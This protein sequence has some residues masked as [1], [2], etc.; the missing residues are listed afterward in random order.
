MQCY[1]ELLPPTG[2]S[3]ALAIPFLSASADNLIVVRSSLLQVFS[4]RKSSPRRLTESTETHSTHPSDTKL[5]LEKEYSLPG[6]V[7]GLSRVKLLNTK[8]GGEAILLAVRNARL[9]L[10]EWDPERHNISTISI[11]YYERDDLTRSPWLPDLSRCPSILSVDP[12]SRCAVF[13]FGVRNLAILPFHQAGDDL[14]MDDYDPELDEER[15]GLGTGNGA[16]QENSKH[17]STY[18]TPYAASFVLPLTALDPSLLHPVSLAF[19][20]EYR[21]PTFGIL[22]S[23]VTTSTALVNERKDVMFYTVFTLDLEQRAS[24]TLL[25]VSRLPTD[26]F[27]IVALPPPV[28][29]A[30]LIG[31]NEI[32]HVDQA[33]K[34]NAVGVNDFSRQVSSFS[35]S[36]QSNL[37][38]RLEGCMVERLGGES[39]DVLLAL[40]SGDMA[41]IKF[42]LDGRSVSGITVHSLPAQAGGNLLNSSASCSTCF[43]D[44]NI[45]LGSEDADSVLLGWSN[46]SISSKKSRQISKQGNDEVEVFSEEDQME[47]DV[48]EDDLYSSAPDTTQA[49]SSISLG[50]STPGFYNFRLNDRLTNIGPLRDITLGKSSSDPTGEGVSSELEL[51]ASQGSDRAGGLVVIKREVDPL[52]KIF[53]QIDDVDAVWSATITEG[54]KGLLNVNDSSRHFVIFSRPTDVDKEVSEIMI[55]NGQELE[56][57]KAPEFNPNEDSTVEI[58]SLANSTRLVQVLQNEVRSYDKDLGLAQIYPVWD[59]ETDE[60]CVAV[61]ARFADPY[62]AILRDDASILLLHADGS[63]DL[64]EISLP[65][66]LSTLKWRS[67]CLYR[68]KD[69][70]FKVLGLRTSNSNESVL[71]FSLSS[72]YKLSIF[73]VPDMKLLSVLDGVDCLQPLLSTDPPRRANTRESLKEILVADLGDRSFTSPYLILRTDND[74]LIVY[75]PVITSSDQDPETSNLRFFRES[76]HTLSRLSSGSSFT[77][78]YNQQ[79]AQPLRVLSDMSGLSTVFMPGESAR[80]IVRTAASSPHSVRLRG[81]YI[82]WL[83]SFN[84]STTGC[85]NGF[86]YIDAEHNIRGCQIHPDTQLDYSWTLRKVLLEEQVDFLTYSTASDTYVL[87]TSVNVDFKLPENDELHPEWR[88]ESTS[89]LPKVPQTSVN[90][91]SP[92]TWTIIDSYPLELAEHIT[93]VKNVNLEISEN[94]HER[95][96]LIVVGT[97]MAKGEDIP[98][99]GCIY[100]FEVIEVVPDPEKPETGRKLKLI[101]KESVK[102]AVTALSGIGGQGF[103]IV[104]QGQ[105]CMVRGLKEDGSLLPVAFMDMQCY[106]NV[107]KELKGTGLVLLGDAVKGLWFA[108]YSEDPYKMTL[109]GKDPEYLEVVAA[110]FL[111]DSNKLYM[112]VADSDC[113]LHVMQYDPEDPKSSNGDR[114]LNRSK[115]YTGNF[116]STVTLLPRTKVS[117]EQVEPTEDEMDVDGSIPA[118]NVLITSQNGS[119]AL[120]TSVVEESYRRLSAMQS[121]LASTLEHPGGLNPRAFRAVESDGTGGRGMVDGNL[122]RQ[123]LN[124]GKQRQTEIA[125]RIG[126]TEWEIRADLEAISGDGLGYL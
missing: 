11:H 94:T 103:I 4:L 7:T 1:T 42:K 111:P 68:D 14:V 36:D 121:Q 124:L 47:D 56:P 126:A 102:G 122:V 40:A 49:D 61:S 57:F 53:L 113:N 91:I 20:Y 93:A 54:K 19:L 119:L 17:D 118:H 41:L 123:W 101:G 110:D 10:I 105:K 84:S 35:M 73:S 46:S 78:L 52:T 96:D 27:K 80:F 120:V 82:R 125:G 8:S 64:D 39:G 65:D 60:E 62:L 38:F 77:E 45:F 28:G 55:V 89:F 75:K 25:S 104:A 37:A 32:V 115:F 5:V 23:Q 51:V 114:L 3:H 12:S 86:I 67:C 70:I 83:T 34:T 33:G 107:A 59:E 108:G 13:N 26:L 22:Y 85:D 76:N 117:S 30:L 21:E 106:V 92:K 74:D 31:T 90:V 2:V 44:G 116:A 97:A 16:D 69:E 50:N 24:T 18:Q 63:G 66:E 15:S 9:S 71:L 48:Y 79:R 29:G 98:A 99:R 6:S 88:N 109:F 100:V 72:E 112:L 81:D 95:K 58:G 87:G 43:D